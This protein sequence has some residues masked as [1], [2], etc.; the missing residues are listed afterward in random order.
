MKK[1]KT[2]CLTQDGKEIKV[3]KQKII[4]R[5]STYGILRSGNKVLVIQAH[6]PLWE[7]PG[8]GVGTDET[9]IESLRR[10]FQ[11]E[12]G[13]KISIKRLVLEKE[14]FYCSPSGKTYHSFQH[15][16]EVKKT[17][18]D[19]MQRHFNRLG[20][21]WIPLKKL[22]KNNMNEGAF[23]ALEALVKDKVSY[24]FLP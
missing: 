20:P 19:L 11:E 6:L 9:L 15:F 10:E 17:G 12:T 5:I 23:A 2:I 4:S 18:G 3:E 16:F 8:G 13:L 1:K 14:S 22:Y 21:T 24:Q 7:F